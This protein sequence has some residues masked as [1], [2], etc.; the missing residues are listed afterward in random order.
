MLFSLIS[1]LSGCLDRLWLFSLFRLVL[2]ILGCFFDFQV[3]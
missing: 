2:V 3:E 1:I